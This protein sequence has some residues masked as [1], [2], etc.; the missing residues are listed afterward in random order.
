M[1]KPGPV[2]IAWLVNYNLVHCRNQAQLAK[3]TGLTQG[4]ISKLSRG[5]RTTIPAWR[6]RSV[7]AGL[8]VSV[9][10]LRRILNNKDT[11]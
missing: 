6:H 5:I 11:P 2:T 1:T 3:A 8:G 7:A 9:G 10:E 4:E